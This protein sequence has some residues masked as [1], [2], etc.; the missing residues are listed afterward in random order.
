MILSLGTHL[1]EQILRGQQKIQKIAPRL[2]GIWILLECLD[3]LLNALGHVVVIIVPEQDVFSPRLESQIQAAIPK[4]ANGLT[5]FYVM[6]LNLGMGAR[7]TPV[8]CGIL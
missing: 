5:L 2:L 3:S 8:L 7:H 1:H 4:L 6:L